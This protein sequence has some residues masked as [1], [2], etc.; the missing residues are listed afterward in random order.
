MYSE[1]EQSILAEAREILC[2]YAPQV[3]VTSWHE[4]TDYVT[5]SYASERSEVFR[6]LF[7]DKKNRLIEDRVMGRGTVDHVP[8]YPREIA[9]AAIELDACACILV[10]NH[11]SGD[12]TPSKA[13]VD[14]TKQ[15]RNALDALG[16]VTHDHIISGRGDIF[17][18]RSNGML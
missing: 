1:H 16:I 11:P 4:L 14:M 18:F 6:V 10:H 5:T 17:S 15:V 3:S 9:R 13:D 7:L 2:R 8:V 12:N